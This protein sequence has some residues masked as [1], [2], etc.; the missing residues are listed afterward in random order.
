VAGEETE[1]EGTKEESTEEQV[2]EKR[3]RNWPFFLLIPIALI[4]G[5]VILI[6]RKKDETSFN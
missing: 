2:L 6:S 5:Y 1:K 4:I 3:I